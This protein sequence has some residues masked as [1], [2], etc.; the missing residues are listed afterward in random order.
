MTIL[1]LPPFTSGSQDDNPTI[2][3]LNHS[4]VF[5]SAIGN[6]EFD[7]G[8]DV[9]MKRVEGKDGYTQIGFPYLAANIVSKATGETLFD[10]FKI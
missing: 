3:T 8:L 1:V 6:H 10:P 4:I 7:R 2:E 5:A 9:L